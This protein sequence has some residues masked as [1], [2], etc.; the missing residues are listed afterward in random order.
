MAKALADLDTLASRMGPSPPPPPRRSLK[1]RA[2]RIAARHDVMPAPPGAFHR[3]AKL[4][5]R[6]ISFNPDGGFAYFEFRDR[7][8]GD[9]RGSIVSTGARGLIEHA[10]DRYGMEKGDASEW[11]EKFMHDMVRHMDRQATRAAR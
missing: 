7:L 1:P 9:M 2:A 8:A 4:P 11:V 6:P 10:H 3:P 5:P